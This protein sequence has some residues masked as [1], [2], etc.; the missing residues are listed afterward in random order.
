MMAARF[1]EGEGEANKKIFETVARVRVTVPSA[2]Y[3][4][5]IFHLSVVGVKKLL[6]VTWVMP[7][8][9]VLSTIK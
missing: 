7:G 8:I 1:A 9:Y 3:V 4:K 5:F 6:V 2:Y